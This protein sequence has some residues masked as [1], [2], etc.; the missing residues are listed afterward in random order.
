MTFLS[1]FKCAKGTTSAHP[2]ADAVETFFE[3]QASSQSH[4]FSPQLADEAT[5]NEVARRHFKPVLPPV[6][7]SPTGVVTVPCNDT[8]LVNKQ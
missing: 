1:F 7:S 6:F 4:L 3:S 8:D 5:P 2:E